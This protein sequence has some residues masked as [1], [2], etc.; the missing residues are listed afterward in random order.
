MGLHDEADHQGTDRT[1]SLVKSRFYWPGMDGDI[2]K[3]VRN[4]LGYIIR[5]A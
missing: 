5:K 4:C 1:M 3:H 2:E